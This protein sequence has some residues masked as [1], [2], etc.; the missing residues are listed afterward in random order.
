MSE[1][2]YKEIQKLLKE[3]NNCKTKA[4]RNILIGMIENILRQHVK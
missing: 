1:K 2:E 4:H 3:I